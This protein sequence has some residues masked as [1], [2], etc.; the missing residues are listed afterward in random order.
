M[1]PANMQG[2]NMA[3]V[4]T[5]DVEMALCAKEEQAQ[6]DADALVKALEEANCKRKEL[7]NKIHDAQAAQEKHEVDQREADAK[8]RGRLL[9]NEAMAEVWRR[10]M[11]QANKARLVVEKLRTEREVSQ[12]LQKV[13]MQLGVSLFFFFIA[14]EAEQVLQATVA[15]VNAVA[16]LSK[17]KVCKLCML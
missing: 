14:F 1:A 3:V 4:T 5:P 13:R 17:W 9:A 15:P 11:C 10:Y 6:Q 16:G 7:A 12:S 8:V 2:T